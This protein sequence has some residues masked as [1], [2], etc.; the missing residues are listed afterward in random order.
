MKVLSDDNGDGQYD[1]ASVLVDGLPFPTAL[2]VWR[3][4]VLILCAPELIYAEDRDGDGRAEIRETLFRGFGRGNPQHLANGL[5]WGLDNWL[6][7]ANGD[8]GGTVESL[9]TGQSVSISGR[10]LRLRV[11]TG[12]LDALSGQTQYGRDRDDWGNWFGGNNNN[13]MWHY[14]LEDRYLRRNPR[15]IPPDVR[16]QVSVRPGPAPVFPTSRTLQRFDESEP[17]NRF[18]ASCTPIIYRDE[19]L[20]TA[21]VGNSFVCESAYNLVHRE[22]VAPEGVSFVSHRAEDERQ[23][24]FLSST[25]NWFRPVMLRTGPDGALWVVDM[26]R[27]VIEHPELIPPQWLERLDLR[28]G[29]TMGRIYRVFPRDQA[30]RPFP[31]LD[32]L[33]T[34]ALVAALD[35]PSGWHRDMAQQMILW[36]RDM[37]AVKLLTETLRSA[38]RPLARLHALCTLDGLDQLRP[39]VLNTALS[40]PHPGVVRHAIRLSEPLLGSSQRIDSA[41]LA[42]RASPDAPVRLQLALSLGQWSDRRAWEALAELAIAHHDQLYMRTAVLSSLT[43]ENVGFVFHRVLAEAAEQE[44]LAELTTR[45]AE[46]LAALGDLDT[47]SAA[48]D[49]I[50]AGAQP[51]SFGWRVTAV[52]AM[53]DSLARR[54]TGAARRLPE[55]ARLALRQLHERTRHILQDSNA[56]QAQLTLA[57]SLLARVSSQPSEDLPLIRGLLSPNQPPSV[58]V[59]A[60]EALASVA[61]EQAPQLLLADWPWQS[62]QVHGRILDEILGRITWTDQLLEAI[63][64]GKVPSAH[65]DARRRQLLLDHDDEQILRH[66]SSPVAGHGVLQLRRGL[67]QFQDVLEMASDPVRG[68]TVFADKCATCHQV[69]GVGQLVGMNLDNLTNR[70]GQALLTAI[71]DPNQAVLDRFLDYSVLLLSGRQT[72]GMIARVQ[73]Q[74]CAGGPEGKF[75]EILRSQIDEMRTTGKSLM[76]EGLERDMSRQ[77]LADVIAYVGATGPEPKQFPGNQPTVARAGQDGSIQLLAKHARVYGPTILFEHEAGIVGNWRSPD[78]QLRWSLEVQPAG[79]YEVVIEYACDD[80]ASG[81]TFFLYV[82]GQT[83][84]ARVPSTGGWDQFGTLSV[85]LVT[86]PAG[87]AEVSI[88]SEG[89]IRSRLLDLRAIRLKSS[90]EETP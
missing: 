9:K 47:V 61:D 62:P 88:S 56:G 50:L 20:G 39:H 75:A 10:D 40:D 64:N 55:E 38:E 34:A 45:L 13:P 83:I 53:L 70:S 59:A 3:R 17:A 31:R 85:G 5:R 57:L 41:V 28:A 67:A 11:D 16:K 7:V 86:L 73:Q 15:L 79:T 63:E 37:T 18:T 24:E 52:N 76:P 89:L 44:T 2:K 6:H 4:G 14:V 81:D 29:D 77:E 1:R 25:D 21:F 42:T 26:Y 65:I 58:Q 27:L 69:E 66:G 23:S 68:K 84:G 33:D 82:A 74:R 46:T 90:S 30:P 54:G 8:S 51:G 80:Q 78:D 36:R 49:Q 48:F 12:Q 72:S 60:V 32:R 71:L 19:L 87:P 43:E 35:H 22:V